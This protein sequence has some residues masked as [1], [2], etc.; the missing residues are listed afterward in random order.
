MNRG[1]STNTKVGNRLLIGTDPRFHLSQGG[2][3]LIETGIDFAGV[4]D[5]ASGLYLTFSCVDPDYDSSGT[6]D[7][8]EKLLP[9]LTVDPAAS[10]SENPSP[11]CGAS[12]S[13]ISNVDAVL[14]AHEREPAGVVLLGAQTFPTYPTDWAPLAVGNGHPEQ[15]D[16][17]QR[18]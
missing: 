4:S 5:G 9:L 2:N 17:R 11:P 6:R 12:A 13:L 18:R 1:T 8:V 15:A 7:G 10:W 3:K 16:L 14:H